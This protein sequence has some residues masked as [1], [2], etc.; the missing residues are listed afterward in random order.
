M[1]NAVYGDLLGPDEP[2]PFTVENEGGRAKVIVIADH[3]S[4]RVPEKLNK[5]GLTDD[6]LGRHWAIDIGS[7]DVAK[8]IAARLDAPLLYCNYSRVVI[9]VNR[10]LDHPTAIPKAGEGK[11]IPGNQLIDTQERE[12]RANAIYYPYHRKLEQMILGYLEQGIVPVILSIHSFTPVFFN[13]RRPWEVAVL[14]T[15]DPRLPV[16][17]MEFFRGKGFTVGDNEPYDVRMVSGSTLHRHADSN[18]LPSLLMEFRN[19]TIDTPEK[20][21][22]MADLLFESL[23]APLQTDTLFTFYDGPLFEGAAKEQEDRYFEELAERAK[24]I[25]ETVV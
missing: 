6:E 2:P 17:V 24:M 1:D 3:A 7:L 18:R 5:L 12:R 9:E 16:P 20:A 22:H 23:E 15:Q 13:Q 10:R 21:G 4:N 25:G 8:A 19:D 14:W 11:E